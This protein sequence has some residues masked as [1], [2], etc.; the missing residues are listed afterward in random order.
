MLKNFI[1]IYLFWEI[2]Y[3]QIMSI[4]IIR[5]ENYMNCRK[6]TLQMTENALL[7]DLNA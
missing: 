7:F 2:N 6:N 4:L 1:E 5:M 3:R